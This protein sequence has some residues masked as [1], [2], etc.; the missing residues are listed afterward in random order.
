MISYNLLVSHATPIFL[1]RYFV[2]LLC[3]M[4]AAIFVSVW[5]SSCRAVSVAVTPT[6]CIFHCCNNKHCRHHLFYFFNDKHFFTRRNIYRELTNTGGIVNGFIRTLH[7]D[8]YL[9]FSNVTWS[10]KLFIRSRL[11]IQM[12]LEITQINGSW[13]FS[14]LLFASTYLFSALKVNNRFSQINYIKYR[15]SHSVW[16]WNS[17]LCWLQ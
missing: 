6:V 9:Y 17:C 8:C 5:V 14:T 15:K 13:Y 10:Y 16:N 7:A 3:L 12:S 1:P 4:S 2:V 11:G